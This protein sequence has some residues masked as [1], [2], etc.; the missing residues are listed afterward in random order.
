MKYFTFLFGIVFALTTLANVQAESVKYK[1]QDSDHIKEI[2]KAWD[3]EKGEY[4]Y[5]SIASMV[6]R[7]KQPERPR[8]VN[9]TPFEMLQMMDERRVDRLERIAEQ[10]LENEKNATRGKRDTYYWQEWKAYVASTQCASMNRGQ[11]NGDPHMTTFDGKK[12]DFQNAGDYLLSGSDKNNF[13]IQTQMI[14]TNNNISQNG[15]VVMNVNGDVVEFRSAQSKDGGMI[16]ING[17]EMLI[18]DTDYTL[19]QGGTIEQSGR[20]T[21]KVKWPTGEQASIRNRGTETKRLFDVTVHVPECNEGEYYG[22]LGDNDG[23]KNNDLESDRQTEE[24]RTLVYSESPAE[25]VFGPNRRNPEVR[26]RQQ[27]KGRY[28]SHNFG[29]Q[30][31]LT[32]NT[33]LFADKMTDIPDSVRYPSEHLTLAELTDEQIEEGLRKARE[34]GV[35][36]DDLFAAVYDYGHIGLEPETYDDEYVHP[37]RE[38][39]YKEPILNHQ[40]S[41]TTPE[42]TN[43]QP[44]VRVEPKGNVGTG[45]I[46]MPPRPVYRNNPTQRTPTST[47]GTST[48]RRT[49]SSSGTPTRTPQRGGGR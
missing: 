1:R 29:D 42:N 32:E 17:E 6:M 37:S 43:Q 35:D 21:H 27:T 28:I 38:N 13:M 4:L 24:D 22:L 47:P 3:D 30:F 49:P 15:A 34:A 44:P 36:E 19:P 48:N 39:K 31:M 16:V 12:Y 20:R 46:I 9:Q 14:R 45:V 10:E 18:D 7:E 25:E 40:G 23:V 33:S 5:E 26:T 2:F 11:S 41:T 8:G